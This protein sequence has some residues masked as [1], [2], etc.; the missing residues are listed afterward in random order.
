VTQGSNYP[1][2]EGRFE[3]PVIWRT[4]VQYHLIVND[5]YGRI[6]YHL[7]SKDGVHWV[8]DPGEAYMPGLA[9]S[10]DGKKDEWYKYERIKVFQDGHG[11]AIQ[12]NFAVIDYSKWEDKAN[13]I[14]SSKNISIPL[15]PGRLLTL[16]NDERI[17]DATHEVR[18]R[19]SA[20]PGFDPHRDI[21]FDSLRFGAPEEVDF[22][23]GSPLV[24]TE[25][26]GPDLV[27]IFAGKL[28]GRSDSGKLL[29]GYTRLPWVCY[30]EPILSVRQP[31][32]IT[33]GEKR[34]LK[35]EVANHGLVV[36]A[37][38][39]IRITASDADT[40]EAACPAIQ[41]YEKT[42]L[43]VPLP[44]GFPADTESGLQIITGLELQQ[45]MVFT[46]IVRAAAFN[47]AGQPVGHPAGA[48][49]DLEE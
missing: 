7:R 3:D 6:A 35:I 31:T 43:E 16:L 21:A 27:A 33:T 22:G 49:F 41:P 11:R 8:V 9:L 5:W 29:F 18:L 32:L 25:K 13:D 46:T 4:R 26:A 39:T 19:I 45:P 1:P 42:H 28:L 17:T 30:D 44:A 48:A 37:P 23:R 47:A 12:A 2:V 15:T 20:E 10:E 40:I 24:R 34:V 36:S 14:H 38:S